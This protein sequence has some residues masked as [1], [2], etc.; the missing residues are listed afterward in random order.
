MKWFGT[1]V[2]PKNRCLTLQF[3]KAGQNV[4]CDDYFE[5]MA[6]TFLSVQF[7]SQLLLNQI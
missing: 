7:S 4:T 5:N 1:N 3:S 2:Y 6:S